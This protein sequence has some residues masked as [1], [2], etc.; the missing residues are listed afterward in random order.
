M[1]SFKIEQTISHSS[2]HSGIHGPQSTPHNLS[3]TATWAVHIGYYRKWYRRWVRNV[4]PNSVRKSITRRNRRWLKGEHA[5]AR[6]FREGKSG[7]TDWSLNG[8][9]SLTERLTS[10]DNRKDSLYHRWFFCNVVARLTWG[11]DVW[12][13]P[14]ICRHSAFRYQSSCTYRPIAI[15]ASTLSGAASATAWSPVQ[16]LEG[17]HSKRVSKRSRPVYDS[18]S[19][20]SLPDRNS[21]TPIL[22]REISWWRRR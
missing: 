14:K 16:V 8:L 10:A 13:G 22:R 11:E 18:S 21:E 17:G 1:V 3:Q 2:H 19:N 6:R 7:L 4:A 20:R 5:I 15:W 12:L 9:S